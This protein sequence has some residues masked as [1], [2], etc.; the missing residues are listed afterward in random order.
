MPV[1]VRYRT[2]VDGHIAGETF[3]VPNEAAANQYHP[4]AEVIAVTPD[5]FLPIVV[6]DLTVEQ[7]GQVQTLI[8]ATIEPVTVNYVI[9][10]GEDPITTGEKGDFRV[11]FDAEITGWALV[12]DRP[13][14]II[15]DLWKSSF[16]DYPP[17][18]AD[19]ITGVNKP[20]LI[21]VDKNQGTL[22]S[23]WQIT[24]GDIFRVYV[25]SASEV[26]RVTLSLSVLRA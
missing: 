2:S 21:N 26:T 8:N 14:D 13:G 3:Q 7:L 12:A 15:I 11:N 23:P 17:S 6:Q 20:T 4:N 19:S 24:Q 5:V 1:I 16:S 22:T 9:D 18:V 10:G 25:Q